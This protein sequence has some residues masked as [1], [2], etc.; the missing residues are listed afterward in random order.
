VGHDGR[1]AHDYV[2][3]RRQQFGAAIGDV[4]DVMARASI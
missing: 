3:G 4:E 2:G 1:A